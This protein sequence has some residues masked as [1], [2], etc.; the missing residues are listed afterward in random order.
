MRYPILMADLIDSR[1]KESNETINNLK[2]IVN[3]VNKEWSTQILSPLTITLGDE[4]QGVIKSLKDAYKI[5]FALEEQIIKRNL[6]FKLRYVIHWGEIETPIN[7]KVAH[8]MLG[9]GLT[10]AREK[11][12]ELKTSKRRFFVL[13]DNDTR[14][15]Q[16]IMNDLFTLYENYVDQWKSKEYHIVKE[17]LLERNY[18]EVAKNLSMNISSAWRR[19]KTLNM[20]EYFICRK[21]ILKLTPTPHD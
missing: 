17:F 18:Q 3:Y 11:L 5:I 1:K 13:L 20:E 6:H 12:N 10:T 2:D 4:F 19:N 14:N 7:D 9:S 16:E 15:N 21:L 8:E